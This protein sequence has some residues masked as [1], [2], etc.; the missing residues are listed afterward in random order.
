MSFWYKLFKLPISSYENKLFSE[1]FLFLFNLD[2]DV[3]FEGSH[4]NKAGLDIFC[5]RLGQSEN[6]VMKLLYAS[7]GVH[8]ET[9][10]NMFK[11]YSG[12]VFLNISSDLINGTVSMGSDYVN[13]LRSDG[14]VMV[15]DKEYYY[16]A[17]RIPM[18]WGVECDE[19]L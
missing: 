1:G 10:V 19:I 18:F 2:R 11:E 12:D 8:K 3:L 17:V 4:I 15:S 7:Y 5:F 16:V 6:N 9:I 14:T 13:E